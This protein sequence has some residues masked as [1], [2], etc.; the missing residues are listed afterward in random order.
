MRQIRIIHEVALSF[1]HCTPAIFS[2]AF[3]RMS[4][5]IKPTT[6][7][8]DANGFSQNDDPQIPNALLVLD[9]DHL[10]DT[11]ALI[12]NRRRLRHWPPVFR[13]YGKLILVPTLSAPPMLV[14]KWNSQSQ[15]R[16]VVLKGFEYH[17]TAQ[18][19]G[20]LP[21]IGQTVAIGVDAWIK[22]YTVVSNLQDQLFLRHA[23][24]HLGETGTRV[25]GNIVDGFF[26]DQE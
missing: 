17:S 26:K 11:R 1:P 20:A 18:I 9:D 14:G 4:Q 16:S 12:W 6:H 25:A 3:V 22:S 5:S 21:H 13:D 8:R 10:D 23:D 19:R 24:L 7:K 2:A 15:G